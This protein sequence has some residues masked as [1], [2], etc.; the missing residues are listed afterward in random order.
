M[1]I[2]QLRSFNGKHSILFFKNKEISDKINQ[3]DC[4]LKIFQM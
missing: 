3:F 4:N 2:H 1:R